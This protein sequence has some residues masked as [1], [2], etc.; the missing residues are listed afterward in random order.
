[1]LKEQKPN[2]FS[3]FRHTR[4]LKGVSI[5]ATF[6]L[7][8]RLRGNDLTS[9]LLFLYSVINELINNPRFPSRR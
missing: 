8:S 1:M 7:D 2:G 4:S 3:S 5:F 9:N 6:N